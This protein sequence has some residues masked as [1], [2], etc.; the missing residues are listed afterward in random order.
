VKTKTPLEN[1]VDKIVKARK[2]GKDMIEIEPDMENES[3]D[4]YVSFWN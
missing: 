1:I 4:R 3:N 2:I